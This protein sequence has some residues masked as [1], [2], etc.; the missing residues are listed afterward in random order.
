MGDNIKLWRGAYK[1]MSDT[2]CNTSNNRK[3]LLFDIENKFIKLN[4]QIIE[5]WIIE[6]FIIEILLFPMHNYVN[7]SEFTRIWPQ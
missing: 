4:I 2:E 6:V 1:S 5:G 7:N 3:S